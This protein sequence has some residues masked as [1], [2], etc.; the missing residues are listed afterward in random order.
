LLGATGLPVNCTR[1][2]HTQEIRSDLKRLG[3]VLIFGLLL[4]RRQA[5]A[6]GL[7]M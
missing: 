5:A 7:G 3:L 1:S 6:W 4:L 2:Q